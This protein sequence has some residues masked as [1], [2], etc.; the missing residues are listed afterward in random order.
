MPF[1]SKAQ[2]KYLY[3]TNPALAS[4]FEKETP[5]GINLPDRVSRQTKRRNRLTQ[6]RRRRSQREIR[7][8]T[9][10]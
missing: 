4:E 5:E 6:R 1:V 8:R 7:R 2:K 10:R 9:S 3:A